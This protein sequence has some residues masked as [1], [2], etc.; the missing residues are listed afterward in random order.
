MIGDKLIISEYHHAAAKMIMEHLR[1][2][3]LQVPYSVSIS[4]E[5]G[6]GKSEIAVVLKEKLMSEGKKALV[7]GQDDYF[8]LPPHSN[9]KQRKLDIN[10][11][12]PM[13]VQL[14]WMN[15]HVNIL[16]RSKEGQVIKPLVHFSEDKIGT[17]SLKGPFDVVIAE[18]TYTS[19]L[20]DINI[21]VFIDGDYRLTKKHRLSRN[22]DQSLDNNS[23]KDLTFLEQVL[24]IE[25]EIISKHKN[26]ANIV[27]PPA[28]VLLSA[29]E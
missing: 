4:G 9:H 27:I 12:G 3:E 16:C 19:L 2:L 18:G 11:V 25:H 28:E 10:W 5:S 17:E 22:R 7:L 1:I 24:Q 6:S 15:E 14:Q 26:L 23:D 29:T 20:S 13:E 8:R 21:R